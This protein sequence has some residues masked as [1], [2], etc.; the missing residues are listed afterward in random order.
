[1]SNTPP[2]WWNKLSDQEK[3]TYY[4]TAV[5]A[6]IDANEQLKIDQA[7][8]KTKNDNINLLI[9]DL[10]KSTELLKNKWHPNFGFSALILA[11]LDEKLNKDV[12]VNLL[13]NKYFLTGRIHLDVGAGI[14]IYEQ[15]GG[16]LL[17]GFG[18]IL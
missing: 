7:S 3:Y 1:M 4:K 16:S 9:S 6:L 12:Y 18:F 17:L 14:K 10:E 15:L 8:I 13:F 2:E 5:N 11:G